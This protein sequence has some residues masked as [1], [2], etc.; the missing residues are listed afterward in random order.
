M[1]GAAPEPGW[2][3]D[4]HDRDRLRYWSGTG[5][6]EHAR[7]VEAPTPP[8]PQAPPAQPEAL[9]PPEAAILPEPVAVPK[10]VVVAPAPWDLPPPVPALPVSAAPALPAPADLPPPQLVAP[11]SPP[12]AAGPPLQALPAPTGLPD[13]EIPAAAPVPPEVGDTVLA[14]P[15]GRARR[16]LL[17]VAAAVVALVV[18]G[19]VV[20][21][22]LLREQQPEVVAA[23]PVVTA[24]EFVPGATYVPTTEL[25]GG[26]VPQCAASAA[27]WRPVGASAVE[28]KVAVKGPKRVVVVAV[29]AEHPE[30]ASTSRAATQIPASGSRHTF[31]VPAPQGGVAQV[32]VA[33]QGADG[34]QRCLA[35]PARR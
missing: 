3:P 27:S 31:R 5:W 30:R 19:A 20:A 21:A 35:A 14:A 26:D 23:A 9:D 34:I 18:V 4:P 22:V 17:V 16:P 24:P 6:T 25:A 33:I 28:V 29:D 12:P 2:Y 8:A 32:L 13:P 11:P 7:A 10:P 1:T 15:G